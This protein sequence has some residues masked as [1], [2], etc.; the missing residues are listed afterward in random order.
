MD[1]QSYFRRIKRHRMQERQHRQKMNHLYVGVCVLVGATLTIVAVAG[2][3]SDVTLASGA[4]GSSRGCSVAMYWPVTDP[5]ITE[6]FDPPPKPWNAG[7]RGID[8]LASQGDMLVAPDDGTIAFAGNVAGKSVVTIRHDELTSTF[9]PAE[10]TYAVGHRVKRGE[11]FAV[12]SGRSDHCREYCIHWGLKT[13]DG[14]Y[15]DPVARTQSWKIV[16]KP[17]TES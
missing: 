17:V 7:H 3:P 12:V 10:T 13:A 1:R 15:I 5:E 6:R 14:A 8:L 9:E 11:H 16:I 4:V 2:A